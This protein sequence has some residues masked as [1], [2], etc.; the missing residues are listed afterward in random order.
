VRG[1]NHP[2]LDN[3]GPP[4]QVDSDGRAPSPSLF[5]DLSNEEFTPAFPPFNYALARGFAVLVCHPQSQPP[6]GSSDEGGGSR[7]VK[8]VV[9]AGETCRRFGL[10]G[11]G[12]RRGH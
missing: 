8:G 5:L 10:A 6:G 4:D 2:T 9:T 1:L 3:L 12:K 7:A 11:I